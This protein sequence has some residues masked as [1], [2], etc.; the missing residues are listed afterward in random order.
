MMQRDLLEYNP[1]NVNLHELIDKIIE[2]LLQGSVEKDIS[3][4]NKVEAKTAVFADAD[5]LRSI[6]QN[7]IN[8][9]I[10]FT[11]NKGMV[12]ISSIYKNDF[13]EVSVQDTGIGIAS[14]K[15]TE[16][17]SFDKSNS[18]DGT[19]GEKGTGLGLVLCK[20]FVER[21]GGEIWVE[22]KIGSGSKFKFTLRKAIT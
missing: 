1:I 14:E 5:M 19:I 15:F 7:L 4:S 16:I 20:E 13:V 17:F 18:K 9:A 3:L 11:H 8:N 12:I 22:S 21:N 6:L 2:T 10:K